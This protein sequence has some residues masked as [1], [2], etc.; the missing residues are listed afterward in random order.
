MTRKILSSSAKIKNLQWLI[1]LH[2]SLI[3]TLKRKGPRTGPYGTP[4]VTLKGMGRVPEIRTRDCL[5]VR[6]PPN[7]TFRESIG[8]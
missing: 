3:N 6:K 4:K 5:L 8:T 2:V 7:V 1:L